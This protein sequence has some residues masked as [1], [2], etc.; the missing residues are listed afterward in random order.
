[1]ENGEGVGSVRRVVEEKAEEVGVDTR[2]L[3]GESGQA[4]RWR[5]ERSVVRKAGKNVNNHQTVV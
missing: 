2:L 4:E 1:M 5:F 3:Y